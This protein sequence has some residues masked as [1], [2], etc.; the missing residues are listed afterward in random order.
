[1]DLN[2]ANVSFEPVIWARLL[3]GRK[4]DI[5]PDAAKYLLSIEFGE[6]DRVRMQE[7]A[8]RSEAGLLTEQEQA[9]FD[10]YLHI[11]NLLAVM[12]SKARIALRRIPVEVPRS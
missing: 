9:E 6:S 11:G 3:E 8:D 7:L 12:Q 2:S 4:D 10:S 1:M 5:P